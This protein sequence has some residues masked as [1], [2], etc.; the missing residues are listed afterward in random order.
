MGG[1]DG[2]SL[3]GRKLHLCSFNI[4]MSGMGRT[5]A[6]FGSV[7]RMLDHLG[8]PHVLGLQ[9]TKLSGKSEIRE[10][11]CMTVPGYHS[12]W[13]TNS[14]GSFYSGVAM[15]VDETIRV[16]AVAGTVRELAALAGAQSL[17]ELDS[18][19]ASGGFAKWAGS[20]SAIEAC[21]SS[22]RSGTEVLPDMSSAAVE[23]LEAKQ[24]EGD[25]LSGE[26]VRRASWVT[27][28]ELDAEGRLIA[29]DFGP[30]VVINGYFPC[31][32]SDARVAYK[33]A[34]HDAVS[35]AVRRLLRAGKEVVLM[36]DLN[37]SHQPIDHCDPKAWVKLVGD[38]GATDDSA[39][40]LSPMLDVCDTGAES[41]LLESGLL[42][43]ASHGTLLPSLTRAELHAFQHGIF[44]RWLD[45]L[46]RPSAVSDVAWRGK[47]ARD[48]WRLARSTGMP[49][50][51]D[52]FRA[53][54]PDLLGAFSCWNKVTSARETNFGTRI[55]Y[56]LV[57][58]ALALTGLQS[59]RVCQAIHGSD[60]CPV[61]A[62]LTLP[63]WVDLKESLSSKPCACAYDPHAWPQFAAKQRTL[64]SFF[65][66]AVLEPSASSA[67]ESSSSPPKPSKSS[68]RQIS[69][70]AMFGAPVKRPRESVSEPEPKIPKL[71]AVESKMAVAGWRQL[72]GGPVR[73]PTCRCSPPQLCVERRVTKEGPNLNRAFFVCSKPAGRKEAGGR[74][75]FFIWAKDWRAKLASAT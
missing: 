52:S 59:A 61:D 58:T 54:H 48:V 45:S 14:R 28:G 42:E 24:T 25:G 6:R 71:S 62:T 29:V 40:P 30:I 74:C 1:E 8:R 63:K 55:D 39:S 44:R 65:S 2:G 12:Y 49:M 70:V 75:D 43:S 64:S 32:A 13:V 4:G 21:E 5:V 33:A 56:V 51:V 22:A 34:F 41:G 9:E 23:A 3:S 18:C 26:A 27:V 37:V 17:Q 57:S 31:A 73:P 53:L 69:L 60:H 16:Q 50:L 36:G 72:L 38:A 19:L 15:F 67:S 46:V 68:T 35:G 47:E 7:A 10:E 66:P 11:W 20:F